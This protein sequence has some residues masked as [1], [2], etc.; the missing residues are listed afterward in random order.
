MTALLAPG[1]KHC[2]KA[3]SMRE[4]HVCLPFFQS[5]YL[6]FCHLSWQARF[7][8]LSAENVGRVHDWRIHVKTQPLG[9]ARMNGTHEWHACMA[10]HA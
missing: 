1:A 2:D 10:W 4:L 9:K 8:A 5:S 3:F 7:H 6:L